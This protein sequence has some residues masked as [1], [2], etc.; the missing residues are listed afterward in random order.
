MRLFS[1]TLF[2]SLF[3]QYALAQSISGVNT[4]PEMTCAFVDSVK[5]QVSKIMPIA[6][7]NIKLVYHSTMSGEGKLLKPLIWK[8]DV[9]NGDEKDNEFVV[10]LRLLLMAAPAWKP[11]FDSSQ[12]KNAGAVVTFA[13][14]ITKGDIQTFSSK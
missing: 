1:T 14:N 5:S 8:E 6:K 2:V 3:T 12:N 13:I 10:K 4:A 9:E 11:A 7:Y